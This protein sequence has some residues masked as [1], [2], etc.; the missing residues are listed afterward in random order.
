MTLGEYWSRGFGAARARILTFS[1]DVRRR[2]YNTLALP[3]ESV[4]KLEVCCLT[5][6][7]IKLFFSSYIIGA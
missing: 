7:L 5:N 1:I 6:C 4:M 3:C 2:H